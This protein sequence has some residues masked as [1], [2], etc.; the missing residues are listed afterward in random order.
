MV[1]PLIEFRHLSLTER[2]QLVADIW[3]SIA[4]HPEAVPLTAT[5]QAEI[6]RR[7][8]EHRRDPSSAIPWE[9]VRAELFGDDE[10]NTRGA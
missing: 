4:E 6:E 3:D 10:E 8:A 2:L 9:Q 5:Q 7:L 1:K